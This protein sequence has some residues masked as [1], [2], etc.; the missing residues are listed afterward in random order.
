MD[1]REIDSKLLKNDTNREDHHVWNFAFSEL[2]QQMGNEANAKL[3]HNRQRQSYSVL[4][5]LF[6]PNP[7]EGLDRPPP[8]HPAAW[9]VDGDLP[10]LHCL[11]A[12]LAPGSNFRTR[13]R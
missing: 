3:E 9:L 7:S 4:H 6:Q 10:A 1:E 11:R 2:C 8:S 13:E 5:C 12:K